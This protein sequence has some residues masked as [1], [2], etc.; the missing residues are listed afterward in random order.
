MELAILF[1][2]ARAREL[3]ASRFEV[4]A[5]PRLG[6]TLP[7]DATRGTVGF[8]RLDSAFEVAPGPWRAHRMVRQQS[9]QEQVEMAILDF[10]SLMLPVFRESSIGEVRIS[11]VVGQLG[12]KLKL[13]E[14]ELSELLP[15]GKQTTFANRVNWAKSYLGKAGLITLTKRAY[16][17]ISERGR[18]VLAS[19]PPVISIKYLESFP[20]FQAFRAA[21]SQGTTTPAPQA[22]NIKELTPDEVIRS[23]NNEL[24]ESLSTEL[25]SRILA[26]PPDFF[27]R[28]VVQLLIAMGYGG[29]AIEAGKALGKSGDGGVDGVIDQD[30]LGLDRIYVQAKRYADKAVSPS[31]VRDFFGSLDRFKA[32]KGLFVTTSTFST[33]ARD[34][35]GQLSKRIVLMDGRQLTV[36]M[37]RFNVGCR[38]EETVEL[39]K[40]DDDFFD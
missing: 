24:Q 12:R 5:K 22:T 11:D 31:E 9:H 7:L 17:E 10:Q 25:L 1:D 29:S 4:T 16:F 2:Q 20:E 19:P 21:S 33:S 27:D 23:A 6:L 14:E 15:S 39:K 35:A 13:S 30:A 36:L 32:S 40:I 28:L 8:G 34:T 26:S 18:K 3:R 37:M 38:V